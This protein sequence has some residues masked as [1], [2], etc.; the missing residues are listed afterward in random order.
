MEAEIPEAILKEDPKKQQEWAWCEN[1]RKAPFERL[2]SWMA[3][4]GIESIPDRTEK[5]LSIY[6]RLDRRGLAKAWTD[7][8]REIKEVWRSW[9]ESH[10]T[11]HGRRVFSS[12]LQDE[13][14]I[15]LAEELMVKHELSAEA[16]RSSVSAVGDTDEGM[17]FLPPW[18]RWV[19]NHPLQTITEETEQGD[20]SLTA[21]GEEYLKKCPNQAARNWLKTIRGDAKMLA[22]FWKQVGTRYSEEV[23]RTD[24]KPDQEESEETQANEDHVAS[25]EEM[26]GM[27]AAG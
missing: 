5:R 15:R 1:F 13:I 27:K 24:K 16:I 18:M 11:V 25:L 17:D 7:L 9:P 12:R 6:K 14:L 23:K 20:E 8:K 4:R 26:L 2:V 10:R 21:I 19:A 22:D 3:K